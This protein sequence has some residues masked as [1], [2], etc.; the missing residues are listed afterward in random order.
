MKPPGPRPP[1]STSRSTCTLSRTRVSGFSNGRSFQRSTITSEDD[2]EAEHEAPAA[3]VGEGRRV[4]G[5]HR[6]ARA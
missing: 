1:A 6:P 4:L 3:G 2:A 5:E